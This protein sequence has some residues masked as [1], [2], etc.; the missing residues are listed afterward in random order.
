MTSP[1]DWGKQEAP[2]FLAD[3]LA[4][5]NQSRRREEPVD[6]CEDLCKALNKTWIAHFAYL[7]GLARKR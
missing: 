3:V 5:I 2:K 1:Q 6:L 4:H 7:P